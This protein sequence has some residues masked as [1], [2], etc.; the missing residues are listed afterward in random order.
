VRRDSAGNAWL[1]IQQQL[2][3]PVVP[4]RLRAVPPEV[5]TTGTLANFKRAL[6][7]WLVVAIHVMRRLQVPNHWQAD[8]KLPVI[9]V[10]S[11]LRQKLL[12]TE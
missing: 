8:F 10:T 6:E 7:G 11:K 9:P 1:G 12:L 5:C 2:Y 3:P 4:A